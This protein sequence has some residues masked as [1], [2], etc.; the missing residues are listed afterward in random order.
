MSHRRTTAALSVLAMFIAGAC[1]SSRASRRVLRVDP[2][3]SRGL[4]LIAFDDGSI[5]ARVASSGELRW[6]SVGGVSDDLGFGA[7]PPETVRCPIRAL[8]GGRLLVVRPS[9]IDLLQDSDGA[10]IATVRI[11]FFPTPRPRRH[12]YS[13][14]PF[15]HRR[16]NAL[17]S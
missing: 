4:V 14:S 16:A 1:T 11:G 8:A 2:I 12:R 9:G 10:R 17:G 7:Q 13:D 15:A 6:T 5:E 3:T